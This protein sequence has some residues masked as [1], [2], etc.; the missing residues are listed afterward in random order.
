MA[1][2]AELAE[3]AYAVTTTNYRPAPI[4]FE[5]G[6]GMWLY[7]AEGKR[8]LDFAA[9]IAVSA[10]GHNHPALTTAIAEQARKLLHVSNLWINRPAVELMER[11][12]AISFADRVYFA[13]SGAEANEAA[14]K[15]ARRYHQAVRG[16]TRRHR[17]VCTTGSF[18]GRTWAAISATGQPKY[19]E[20]FGPLVP[21]FD[22]VPY[23]DVAA[24]EAAI[25]D[26]TAAVFV[27]PIQGEGGILVP[28]DGY[29][30]ALRA[31][32]D[33]VGILL[34]L[35]EVQT[36]VG[37]T[38]RWF[39]YQH[40]TVTP[41]IMTLAKGL[42]GGVP[43]GAMLC[44]EEV[45]R[46]F[47]PGVHASTYGGNP[48][49]CAASLAVFRT[50]DEDRLLANAESTGELLGAGL[51]DLAGTVDGAVEGRGLGLMRALAV[52]PEAVDRRAVK[53]ACEARGLLITLAGPDALRLTPPLIAG[54]AHVEQA[55]EILREALLD[56]VGR[57][58]EATR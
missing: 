31:L 15:I 46:G 57:G 10:L 54:P 19:H 52:D 39:A 35:D 27:E 9:G 21:G 38:G 24:V 23:G 22:H 26:E 43:I 42:G 28:A 34:I 48:L 50:L 40:S 45:G 33:R 53:A 3:R 58:P 32:C 14:L 7:D 41:D 13:N 2:Q 11:L 36:G 8:Y 37:R 30:E 1:T 55:L 18:H 4:V 56:V 17:F 12:T 5:R 51:D 20:G 25:T 6:E 49:V 16:D 29:L 44:T 47:V